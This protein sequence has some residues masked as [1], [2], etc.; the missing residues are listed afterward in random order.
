MSAFGLYSGFGIF[1]ADMINILIR[2]RM[3]QDLMHLRSAGGGRMTMCCLVSA[4]KICFA[5]AHH[6]VA[7]CFGK[8]IAIF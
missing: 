6:F 3:E 7:T 4:V 5:P 1:F 2:R 8:D